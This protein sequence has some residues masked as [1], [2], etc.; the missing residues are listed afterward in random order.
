MSRPPERHVLGA[1]GRSKEDRIQACEAYWLKRGAS[2]A[3]LA[4][5]KMSDYSWEPKHM[6]DDLNV[7]CENE[8]LVF[9]TDEAGSKTDEAAEFS[10]VFVM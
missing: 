9:E 10:P 5:W 8:M 2:C 6:P 4:L 1:G 3:A 7:L